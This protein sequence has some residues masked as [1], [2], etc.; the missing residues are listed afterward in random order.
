MTNFSIKDAITHGLT[1]W[2]TKQYRNRVFL[3]MIGML[4][5]GYG[6]YFILLGPLYVEYFATLALF[7]EDPESFATSMQM[8]S[9]GAKMSLYGMLFNV[10][11]MMII[12]SSE[13]V[14]HKNVFFN[15]ENQPIPHRLGLSELKVIVVQ[16]VVYVITMIAMFISYFAFI[17]VFILLMLLVMAAAAIS[18]VLGTVVGVILGFLAI[19]F[20][21]CVIIY[22][23]ARMSPAAALT[24]RDDDIRIPEA[25]ALTKGIGKPMMWSY[26]IVYLVYFLFVLVIF[27][28]LGFLMFADS[29]LWQNLKAIDGDVDRA[30][31]LI[32]VHLSTGKAKLISATMVVASAVLL[33]IYYFCWA[34]IANYAVVFKSRNTQVIYD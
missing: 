14:F 18:P 22:I 1:G 19:M 26:I 28:A 32:G 3:L 15:T 8:Q 24:V 29:E 27:G 7:M 31:E 34:G 21:M 10:L 6:L 20:W 23:M 13:T 5:L 30:V 17:I 11:F 4:I 16:I 2:T 12:A 33:P 9:M 25:W